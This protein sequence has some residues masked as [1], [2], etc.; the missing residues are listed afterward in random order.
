LPEPSASL[1]DGE[2][3]G[4]ELIDPMMRVDRAVHDAHDDLVA[5]LQRIVYRV[6]PRSLAPDSRGEHA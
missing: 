3:C 2:A 5:E 6:I 1:D 4:F